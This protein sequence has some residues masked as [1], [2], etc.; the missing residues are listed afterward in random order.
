MEKVVYQSKKEKIS[1][2]KVHGK[3]TLSAGEV[4]YLRHMEHRMLHLVG[5]PDLLSQWMEVL[6]PPE[7]AFVKS[8]T[9][10]RRTFAASMI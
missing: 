10:S 1:V 9:T 5:E 6:F 8:A 4:S 7:R 2:P 3:C